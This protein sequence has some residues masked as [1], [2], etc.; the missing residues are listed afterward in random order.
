MLYLPKLVHNS[1]NHYLIIFNRH[2]LPDIVVN[3][4]KFYLKP[5]LFIPLQFWFNMNLG[6]AMPWGCLSI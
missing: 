6:S 3:K 5:R 1:I 2:Q 4:I